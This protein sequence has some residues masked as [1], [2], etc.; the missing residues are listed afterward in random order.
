MNLEKY[1]LLFQT[2][3]QSSLRRVEWMMMSFCS[4]KLIWDKPKHPL[5]LNSIILA[6]RLM[7][8]D[9]MNYSKEELISSKLENLQ[10]SIGHLALKILYQVQPN[11]SHFKVPLNSQE[12]LSMVHKSPKTKTPS[13]ATNL[14]PM[15]SSSTQSSL[16]TRQVQFSKPRTFLKTFTTYLMWRSY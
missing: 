16:S 13:Y 8:K 10:T 6:S 14:L 2:L 7:H 15:N 12:D 5:W 4:Q 9:L 1:S 11:S 3:I